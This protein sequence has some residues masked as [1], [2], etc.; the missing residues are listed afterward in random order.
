[1]RV[2]VEGAPGAVGTL[3]VVIS[4]DGIGGADPGGAGLHGLADR[5]SGI[6]GALSVESPAGGP[7]IISAILPC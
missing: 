6:D 7:T 4:D 3:N 1:V 5:I 2:V